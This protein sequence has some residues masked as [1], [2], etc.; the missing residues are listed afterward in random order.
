MLSP[1]GKCLTTFFFRQIDLPAFSNKFV[2]MELLLC[3]R[4]EERSFIL[5][6]RTVG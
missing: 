5:C 2:N 1:S 6:Y 3:K 4:R